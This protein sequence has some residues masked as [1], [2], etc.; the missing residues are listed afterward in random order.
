MTIRTKLTFWYAGV[1][2]ASLLLCSALLYQEWVIEPQR[3]HHHHRVERRDEGE[4]DILDLAKSLLITA[5]PAAILGLGGGWLIMHKALAPVAALTKAAE[6]L[7]ES[8]LSVR[9]PRSGNGD[10]LDRLTSVFNSMTLRLAESFSRIREFTLRASHELK[11]PLTIIRGQLELTLPQP[12]LSAQER[13]RLL[14]ELDEIDRLAK[15]VDG[16]TLLTKA[17]AGFIQLKQEPLRLDTLLRDTFDD[18]QVLAIPWNVE[19]RLDQC[20]EVT[21]CGDNYRLRQV[22]L[23]L[24][25]NALKYNQP[26]GFVTLALRQAGK[27][28]EISVTNT[29]PGVAPEILPRLFDPFFRG[30]ASHN[31]S[32]DGSGLGLAIARWIVTAHGGTLTISSQEA[33]I[34]T[35]TLRLP[36]R[37]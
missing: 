5:L 12:Q 2:F 4:K 17:D 24:T 6:Q 15:I 7:N 25:D 20:E 28:A 9:L 34:T 14:D 23:N 31:R 36:T 10:E 26:G 8:N 30:D 27:E 18:G 35:A 37:L 32:V 13:E 11:T 1:L 33:G 21:V 16:L 29:G 19:I 3:D 22:L